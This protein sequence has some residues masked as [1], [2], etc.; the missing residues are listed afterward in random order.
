MG[1]NKM[2]KKIMGMF[3]KLVNRETIAYGIAG[4][5]TTIVNFVSYEGLYRLG[6]PNLTANALAWVIAVIFAYIVNKKNVFL[7]RS[8]SVRDEATKIS[9]FFG[10]RI[11]TL[12]VEQTGMY[13]F[14]ELVQFNRLLVKAGLAV[15]VIILNYIFSKLY[16]FNDKAAKNHHQEEHQDEHQE[17][18]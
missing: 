9:K 7:S 11:I 14:T 3:H 5:L 10:A 13:L 2:K 18:E 4:V 16:I 6:V 12:L 8:D 1:S 17:E 15:I